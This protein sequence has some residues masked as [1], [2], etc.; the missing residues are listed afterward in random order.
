MFDVFIQFLLPT[1]LNRFEI[2][3]CENMYIVLICRKMF[4][5]IKE[6]LEQ[7]ILANHFSVSNTAIFKSK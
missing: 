7:G 3:A 6:K 1:P 2:C 4:H 5:L